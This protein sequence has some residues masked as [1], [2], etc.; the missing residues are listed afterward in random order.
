MYS[1]KKIDFCTPISQEPTKKLDYFSPRYDNILS[2]TAAVQSP[3]QNLKFS[4][5]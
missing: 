2:H 5:L 4:D 3:T 1:S